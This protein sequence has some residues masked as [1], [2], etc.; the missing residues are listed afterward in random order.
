MSTENQT[1]EP[2]IT[3]LPL[4]GR[5]ERAI[6]EMG[7]IVNDWA[8]K[9][10]WNEP[11]TPEQFEISKKLAALSFIHTEISKIAEA[12]R[13]GEASGEIAKMLRDLPENIPFLNIE[14]VIDSLPA[15]RVEDLAQITLSHSE[16]SEA[17]DAVTNNANDDHLPQI[18]GV[19]AELADTLIRIFHFVGKR[20][21]NLGSALVAKHLYNTKRAH[22][23]GKL[24]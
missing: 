4:L 21:L 2:A 18:K 10:G 11:N 22:R 12:L 14:E 15:E 5:H 20:G 1:E 3:F 17:A 13:K 6:D 9:K 23:H 7:S 19:V 24:K 8:E 16:L